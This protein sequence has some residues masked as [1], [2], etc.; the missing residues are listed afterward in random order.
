M[1]LKKLCMVVGEDF[2]TFKETALAT[3]LVKRKSHCLDFTI[4]V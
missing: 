2:K 1:P 4:L 3:E